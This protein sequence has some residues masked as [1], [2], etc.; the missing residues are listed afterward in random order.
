VDWGPGVRLT[1]GPAIRPEGVRS[2]KLRDR[3]VWADIDLLFTSAVD[4]AAR[5]TRERDQ[6]V[7]GASP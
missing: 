1:L 2:G 4:E 3:R 6:R 5:L 7:E